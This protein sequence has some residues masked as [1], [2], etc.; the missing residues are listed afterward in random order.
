M[1]GIKK[2]ATKVTAAMFKAV[3]V[4]SA[5]EQLQQCIR[6][7]MARFNDGHGSTESKLEEKDLDA[8]DVVTLVNNIRHDIVPSDDS[9]FVRQLFVALLTLAEDADGLNIDT[10]TWFFEQ[11][12]V[13]FPGDALLTI[14]RSVELGVAQRAL[15]DILIDCSFSMGIPNTVPRNMLDPRRDISVAELKRTSGATY[16]YFSSLSYICCKT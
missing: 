4:Q 3:Q 2:S 16:W 6:E 13:M 11:H 12:A 15:I 14:G 5:E 8:V 9:G 1:F 7:A 10:A